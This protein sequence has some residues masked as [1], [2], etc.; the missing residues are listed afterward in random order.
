M[1][2]NVLFH[3]RAVPIVPT[4]RYKDWM[5]FFMPAFLNKAMANLGETRVL[6]LD[7]NSDIGAHV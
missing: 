4:S 3:L 5:H 6:I 1:C 7:G 2:D